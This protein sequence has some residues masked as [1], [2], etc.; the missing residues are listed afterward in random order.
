MHYVRWTAVQDIAAPCQSW[1]LC[2]NFFYCVLQVWLQMAA[3]SPNNAGSSQMGKFV[4]WCQPGW[5]SLCSSLV[6][7]HAFSRN[8][9]VIAYITHIQ[10][11][12]LLWALLWA[13][14][15]QGAFGS[16][17][18]CALQTPLSSHCSML[19]RPGVAQLSRTPAAFAPR[20][21]MSCCPASGSSTAQAAG[22]KG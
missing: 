21:A 17:R 2:I 14:L 16:P 13:P 15:G 18:L 3:V 6:M 11:D 12:W 20:R 5:Q 4:A 1:K 8:A 9:A 22:T 19:F 10:L 7:P